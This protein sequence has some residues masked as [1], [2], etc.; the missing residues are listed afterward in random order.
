MM[1]FVFY[2]LILADIFV[3][4]KGTPVVEQWLYLFREVY[5]MEFILFV[6]LIY[7]Y[8]LHMYRKY[9]ISGEI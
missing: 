7:K 5:T 2:G 4:L 3:I 9:G 1:I 8:Q 6:G